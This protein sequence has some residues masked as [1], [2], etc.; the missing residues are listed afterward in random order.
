MGW[1]IWV[2]AGRKPLDWFQSCPE[3]QSTQGEHRPWR[4]LNLWDLR[5]ANCLKP[6]ISFWTTETQRWDKKLTRQA[7]WFCFP[8][9]WVTLYHFANLLSPQI[10][11]IRQNRKLQSLISSKFKYIKFSYSKER[12]R[13]PSIPQMCLQSNISGTHLLMLL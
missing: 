8:L 9:F 6:N 5:I 13:L 7:M 2:V 1:E 12:G 4:M 10:L 3:L 11:P